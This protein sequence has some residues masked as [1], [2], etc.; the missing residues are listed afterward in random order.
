[1]ATRKKTKAGTKKAPAAKR[2]AR[3]A[4]KAPRARTAP[5]GLT[6]SSVAPS[7]TV[8]DLE[9]SIAWYRDVLGLVVKDRWEHEGQLM[10]VEMQAGGVT[11]MLGQDDWKKGRDRV[12]GEGF[13]LYSET[14]QD[15]DRLAEQIKA[16]GGTLAQEPKD[17]S[18]GARGFSVEDPDGYKISIFQKRRRR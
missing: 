12:K 7:F 18:W 2:P 10:G 11:F 9:K 6:L 5:P 16:R 15:A 17:E 13:R 3:R 14:T 1:M 4:S 8:N